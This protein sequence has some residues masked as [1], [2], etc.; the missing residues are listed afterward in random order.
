MTEVADRSGNGAVV[1]VVHYG[2]T[3][4]EYL[5]ADL[6]YADAEP[7]VEDGIQ[8]CDENDVATY[9]NCLH[10]GYARALADQG[11]WDE[12][13]THTRIVLESAAS[14]I[15]RLFSLV[16]AGVIAA[17]RGRHEEA[18]V[19]LAEAQE[20]S[21]GVGERAYIAFT[22]MALAEACWLQGDTD[23]ARGHLAVARALLT[24]LEAPE[25]AGIRAWE[26]R[27]VG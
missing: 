11:R 1:D 14:P 9:G 18:G 13:L 20:V 19:F 21:D 15:N 10:G 2:A 17:R 6:R 23:D 25:A 7:L 12:A 22:R 5:H 4:T 27:L 16:V 26:H 8:Y 3:L 24:P